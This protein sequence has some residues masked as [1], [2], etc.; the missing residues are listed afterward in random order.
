[1]ILAIVSALFLISTGFAHATPKS[2]HHAEAFP[3]RLPGV[4]REVTDHHSGEVLRDEA[5][6]GSC[7]VCKMIVTKVMKSLG[8]DHS[9][10]KIDNLL[11]RVCN[12]TGPLRSLCNK[13]L[14]RFKDKL[15]SALEQGGQ[16]RE[17]CV[18][19][20]LCKTKRTIYK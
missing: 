3:M 14:S 6:P 5:F 11:N 2:A 4:V 16:P 19:L 17:I 18:R 8:N 12:K 20:K 1:M 15:A 7:K 9:R 10:E 13:V